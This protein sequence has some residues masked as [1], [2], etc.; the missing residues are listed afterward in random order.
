MKPR[1]SGR[2]CRAPSHRCPTASRKWIL[3]LNSPKPSPW[4]CRATPKPSQDC[5]LLWGWIRHHAKPLGAGA[6]DAGRRFSR[7]RNPDSPLCSSPDPTGEDRVLR[8]HDCFAHCPGT[9]PSANRKA[10]R[11]PHGRG[12]CF[13]RRYRSACRCCDRFGCGSFVRLARW[14]SAP[15]ARDPRDKRPS[16]T[17]G[18]AECLDA[19]VAAA[20]AGE[21]PHKRGD[22]CVG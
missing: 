6:V 7:G 9:W 10:Q 14:R 11:N 2:R 19:V 18:C 15:R 5:C 16:R 20:F 12:D 17:S 21:A 8:S 13:N 22:G 4:L 1:Q 3:R